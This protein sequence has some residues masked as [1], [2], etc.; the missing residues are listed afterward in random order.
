MSTIITGEAVVLHLRP[1][2]FVLRAVGCIIDYLVYAIG[3]V[4]SLILLERLLSGFDSAA[5]RALVI[6]LVVLWLVA[7]PVTVETLSRG[8]SLGRLVMG[9]R[10]V[11]DDG[12][13]IRFR[14][15]FIRALLALLEILSLFGS[16]ALIV[17]FSNE[18]GKRLGDMLAGTYSMRE[19]RGKVTP[20]TVPVPAQ[21]RPWAELADVGRIPDV[22]AGRAA[23][24][25]RQAPSM[26]AA[27]RDRVAVELANELRPLVSPAPPPCPPEQFLL[28][29]VA[30][31]RERDYRRLAATAKRQQQMRERIHRLPYDA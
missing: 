27:S 1:A 11:R 20:L 31:R 7:V 24:Y 18:R 12:G 23:R 16:L 5:A 21:L 14:H 22:L 28:A 8:K 19:R 15:A 3:L 29:V 26:A 17:S 30:E 10:I 13:S 9:L 4:G 2:S 6:A 25:I